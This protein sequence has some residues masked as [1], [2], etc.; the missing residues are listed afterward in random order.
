MKKIIN[1]LF[2]F[3]TKH[4]Q[5]VRPKEKNIYNAAD[6]IILNFHNLINP[7]I[8]TYEYDSEGREISNKHN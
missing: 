2:N 8:T 1:F 4:V 3:L 5:K 6:K 7:A